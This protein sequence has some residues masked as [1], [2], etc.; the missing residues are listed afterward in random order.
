[1]VVPINEEKA[2]EALNAL[3][4]VDDE[5]YGFTGKNR[6]KSN[7]IIDIFIQEYKRK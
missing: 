7:S 6:T 4:Y 5:E 2:K 1:M 3:E